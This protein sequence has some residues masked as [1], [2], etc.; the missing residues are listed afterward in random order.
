M[1]KVH[2]LNWYAKPKKFT[3]GLRDLF[4]IDVKDGEWPRVFVTVR[5][6]NKWAQRLSPGDFVDVAIDGAVFGMAKVRK[7]TTMQLNS[8]TAYDL[9]HNIGAKTPKAALK[10]MKKAYGEKAVEPSSTITLIELAVVGAA[11]FAGK[12]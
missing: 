8:L 6:G 9:T 4:S 10:D 3:K 7:I 5:L 12:K 11:V 1:T 2:T